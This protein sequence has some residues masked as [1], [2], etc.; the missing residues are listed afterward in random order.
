MDNDFLFFSSSII[1]KYSSNTLTQYSHSYIIYSHA[2][3]GLIL[4]FN[5]TIGIFESNILYKIKTNGVKTF[6]IVGILKY[7]SNSF[8]LIYKYSTLVDYLIIE[9]ID[10]ELIIVERKNHNKTL[11]SINDDNYYEYLENYNTQFIKNIS[12]SL[13]KLGE[14]NIKQIEKSD[15]EIVNFKLPILEKFTYITNNESC[16]VLIVQNVVYRFEDNEKLVRVNKTPCY[17]QNYSIFGNFLIANGFR[18]SFYV[19]LITKQVFKCEDDFSF[20]FESNK[21]YYGVTNNS[22]Y[23]I[24]I[25]E[26]IRKYEALENF[27]ID[28]KN[29]LPFLVNPG[30]PTYLYCSYS[31]CFYYVIDNFLGKTFLIL[32]NYTYK[33]YD[34]IF[35]MFLIINYKTIAIAIKNPKTGMSSIVIIGIT[36]DIEELKIIESKID[37]MSL[38]QSRRYLAITYPNY[39]DIIDIQEDYTVINRVDHYAKYIYNTSMYANILCIRE[40]KINAIIILDFLKKSET[41]TIF[42]YD[43]M[44]HKLMNCQLKLN[45]SVFEQYKDYIDERGECPKVL[46]EEVKFSEMFNVNEDDYDVML[47]NNYR[48][49]GFDSGSTYNDFE[50]IIRFKNRKLFITK[51]ILIILPNEIYKVYKI[52]KEIFIFCVDGGI[53]VLYSFTFTSHLKDKYN[54]C[55]EQ[56]VGCGTENTNLDFAC[57]NLVRNDY[58]EKFDELA[59]VTRNFSDLSR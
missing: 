35:T 58:P 10:G 39:S 7:Q 33:E 11:S 31:K 41:K 4:Y 56:L 28:F 50:E 9:Y 30:N 8:R 51:T 47:E 16:N 59:N 53:Y 40:D 45:E 44:L 21:H 37:V 20:T 17:I 13:E 12:F 3:L 24:T 18:D 42:H 29:L 1:Y 46:F 32:N 14:L 5:D 2:D 52:S 19:D 43:F 49:F 36:F 26:V 23:K 15:Y 22:V 54:S 34:G 57:V 38:A 55:I 6:T 27:K 25:D 48:F